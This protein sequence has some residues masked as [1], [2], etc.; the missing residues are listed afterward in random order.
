MQTL[1]KECTAGEQRYDHN[2]VTSRHERG[3]W[4]TPARGRC[5]PQT[6]RPGVTKT[7]AGRPTAA[8]SQVKWHTSQPVT[9][10][11][12]GGVRSAHQATTGDLLKGGAGPRGRLQAGHTQTVHCHT[13]Y[14]QQLRHHNPQLPT[15]CAHAAMGH[16]SM[17]GCCSHNTHK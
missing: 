14:R 2:P 11:V 6:Q 9:A 5:A 3:L 1:H 8:A 16:T 10:G 15:T 12:E 13:Q 7:T 17:Q 4:R